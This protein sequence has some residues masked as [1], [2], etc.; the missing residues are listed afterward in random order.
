MAVGRVEDTACEHSSSGTTCTRII[1]RSKDD[2]I[3]FIKRL[4][5]YGINVAGT[6]VVY[7]SC[8]LIVIAIPQN[9]FIT[10]NPV[11]PVMSA[12]YT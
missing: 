7:H 12:S 5:Y 2:K 11:D 6:F 10:L 9:A 1:Y 3:W 4:R 8:T